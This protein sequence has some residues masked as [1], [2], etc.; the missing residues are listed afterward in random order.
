MKVLVTG[1]TGFL[2]GYLV[3]RLL[4][5]GDQVTVASRHPAAALARLPA[6]AFATT[7]SDGLEGYDAIV[8]LAGEP[9]FGKRWDQAQ[10]RVLRDSR[11]GT[12][13]ALVSGIAQARARPKVLV[14]ASAIGYYGPRYGVFAD[15]PLDEG[16]GPGND[17]LADVCRDWERAARPAEALGL[18]VV[19]PRI[20]VVLGRGGGAF[21]MF[22]RPFK[23]FAGGPI[24]NG[25]Q[26]FSW[27][28]VDDLVALLALALDDAR[29]T[30]PLNCTA[31]GAQTNLEFSQILA[32]ILHRPCFLRT[33]VWLMRLILGEVGD[34]LGSGQRVAPV[35]AQALGFAF[36]FPTSEAALADLLA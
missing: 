14:S 12:T 11:V 4:E 15:T 35:K 18:R 17:F 21:P 3:R 6:G 9:I 1:G 29:V 34:L 30:G 27:I 22:L 23:G 26:W 20:G 33:P 24:G 31:P 28:H 36:R 13:E 25:R 10:K 2:G 16:T 32:R 8:N 5:R 19:T 7:V